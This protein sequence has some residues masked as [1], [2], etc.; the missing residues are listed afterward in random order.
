MIVSVMGTKNKQVY[1]PPTYTTYPG[2]FYGGYYGHYSAY[3]TVVTQPGYYSNHEVLLLDISLYD[4]EH[5][6]PVWSG[7]SS[8]TDPASVRTLSKELFDLVS[9]ELKK[10]GLLPQ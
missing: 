3:R 10:H 2:S 1:N 6:K 7:V 8:T 4:L 9:K 5:D